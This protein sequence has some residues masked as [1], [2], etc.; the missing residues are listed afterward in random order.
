MRFRLFVIGLALLAASGCDLLGQLNGN[1]NSEAEAAP[2]LVIG[3][4]GLDPYIVMVMRSR[5][6]LPHLDALMDRGAHGILYSEKE[7]RSP[8]LWTTVATGRPR[9]VHGIYDFVTGSK[10]WPEDQRANKKRLVTSDMRR[11]DALWNYATDGGRTTA[12]VGWLNTW[13]A[14]RIDGVV[15][16]P[17][18]AL[19]QSKQITIKGAVYEDEDRQV[20]PEER[21][22]ELR[23]LVV[24][25]DEVPA[26]TVREFVGPKHNELGRIYPIL[27]RYED[28]LRWSLAH[29]DTMHA[30]TM[31]L[32]ESDA[33][34]LTMVYFEGADSLGHRFWL[35][36]ESTY[37]I[38]RTLSAVD[39]SPRYASALKATYGDVLEEYYRY[40]DTKIG[41]LV[42]A[43][44]A[45]ATIL[46]VSDHGFGDWR[47][48]VPPLEGT[49]FTGQ[50]RLEGFVAMAGPNVPEDSRLNGAT[51]Y[52]VAPTVL[53][54]LGLPIPEEFEGS[55]M[56]PTIP[57]KLP[58]VDA[59]ETS[60]EVERQE[61]ERLE[62]LGYVE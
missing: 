61:L 36:R 44:P 5:G 17:Y 42:E 6:E 7:I 40:V 37:R 1:G 54:A 13:P 8:A 27:N 52:D 22:N 58:P 38:S 55:V 9:S 15:V 2:V 33:P 62:S 31:S 43:A 51:L 18:V 12:V 30:L 34:D 53:D 29:T 57:G 48:H 50:H 49:P 45:G 56:V 23:P 32:M 41:E 11:V 21:W 26:A 39:L 10:Y 46:V 35:F 19:G 47:E 25:K 4:D 24:G 20:F 60:D 3:V 59:D 14:E 28:G 16:A